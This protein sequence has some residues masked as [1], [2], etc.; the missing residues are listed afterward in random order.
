LAASGCA[1]AGTGF[2]APRCAARAI[3]ATSSE[4]A[5]AHET[6]PIDPLFTVLP[7]F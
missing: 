5:I 4:N 1:A 3:G 6:I 7:T 2:A